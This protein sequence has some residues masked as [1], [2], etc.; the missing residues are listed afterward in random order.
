MAMNKVLKVGDHVEIIPCIALLQPLKYDRK[1]EQP[2]VEKSYP[3]YGTITHINYVNIW[4]KPK[5][6]RWETMCYPEE[7]KVISDSEF[8]TI[9]NYVRK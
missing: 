1:Y 9:T 4:V 6:R 2:F 5:Y 3:Q 8:T 7:L